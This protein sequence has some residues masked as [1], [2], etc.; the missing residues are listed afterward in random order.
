MCGSFIA[1]PGSVR[2]RREVSSRVYFVNIVECIM[3]MSGISIH[4]SF[5]VCRTQFFPATV[6]EQSDEVT[7]PAAVE[8]ATGAAWAEPE[9][10]A[11]VRAG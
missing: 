5:R 4:I 6:V 3:A 10:D 1:F 7:V 9:A 8:V 2:Q 11:I